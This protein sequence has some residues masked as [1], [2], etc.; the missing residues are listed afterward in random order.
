MFIPL[1]ILLPNFM[2]LY[3][4]KL[5]DKHPLTKAMKTTEKEV[6]ILP[7]FSSTRSTRD[8]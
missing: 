7:Q 3:E 1:G 6:P 2:V 5:F 8:T 4:F